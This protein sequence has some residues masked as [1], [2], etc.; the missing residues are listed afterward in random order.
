MEDARLRLPVSIR[1]A[2][3]CPCYLL[4][5][6][7]EIEPHAASRFVGHRA[8]LAT[9][10]FPPSTLAQL[11]VSI[12]RASSCPCYSNA[13]SRAHA[14]IAVSI[15]RASSC[16]CYFQLLRSNPDEWFTSRFVGHRAA[17]ATCSLVSEALG[18]GLSRFVGHRAALATSPSTSYAAYAAA[19][20]LSRFVGHRAALAT[21]W[22]HDRNLGL[23][24]SRFVGH[25][26]ALATRHQRMCLDSV[27]RVSIRRASS[28]PCYLT[29][30]ATIQALVSC[31]NS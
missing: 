15:R 25:R 14:R 31:L 29:S 2:S 16:P 26:A 4:R 18:L 13:W 5:V 28:C 19:T 3:S 17:L 23:F 11:H 9:I 21:Q 10:E 7:P 30:R 27:D 24:L 8:A 22:D 6:G 12:R 20:S 1:R